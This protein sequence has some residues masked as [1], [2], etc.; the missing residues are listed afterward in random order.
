VVEGSSS[1]PSLV[2]S[3]LLSLLL[4]SL[5]SSCGILA[6]CCRTKVEVK[7]MSE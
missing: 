4:L 6:Y 7:S 3:L 5:S 2:Y 1:T